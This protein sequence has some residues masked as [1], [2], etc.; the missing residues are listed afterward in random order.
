MQKVLA[1]DYSE[2]LTVKMPLCSARKF[3]SNEVF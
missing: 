1:G 3:V 2:D